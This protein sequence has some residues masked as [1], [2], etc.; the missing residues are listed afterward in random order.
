MWQFMPGTGRRF[1]R[2]DGSVDERLDPILATRAAAQF[3]RENYIQLGTWP[4]AI[5]AYNHGPA[6]IARAVR[7]IGTTDAA[8]IIESYRGPS[9]KFASRNFFPEFLAA[10]HVERNYRK[11]FGDLPLDPP[12]T[13]DTVYLAGHTPISARGALRRNRPVGYRRAQPE[14]ARSGQ[15][16]AAANSIRLRASP[17]ARHGRP[18]ALLRG[19]STG[20]V[21]TSRA[22]CVAVAP[23]RWAQHRQPRPQDAKR[24]RRAPRETRPAWR[25]RRPLR[26][27]GRSHPA[28]Q[29]AQGN[30][31]Q[32]VRC[33][34]SRPLAAAAGAVRVRR[35][36]VYRSPPS[37]ATC[38]RQPARRRRRR[39]GGPALEIF[40]HHRAL[41]IPV[42]YGRQRTTRQ[43]RGAQRLLPLALIVA[44]HDQIG[45]HR[46]APSE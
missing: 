36:I 34:A 39:S 38:D 11:Y 43:S 21:A 10:L 27:L 1:L 12:L 35:S 7:D 15:G 37:T 8:T 24:R 6:G 23:R 29:Q 40:A 25:N 31:I 33:C 18:G 16:W 26:L 4:L 17:A 45:I 13:A 3:M 41:Q 22:R 19:Q 14:P 30:K 20:A 44:E 2:I 28:R 5:K 32:A 46:G 42:G 9:Y